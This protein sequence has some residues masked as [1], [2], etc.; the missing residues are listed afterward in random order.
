MRQ[1]HKINKYEAVHI[2]LK[3][4]YGKAS[5]CENEKCLKTST[6]YQWALKNKCRY[7]FNRN[8]FIQLCAKCHSA[9]DHKHKRK[10]KWVD[11]SIRFNSVDIIL[12]RK[13]AQIENRTIKGQFKIIVNSYYKSKYKE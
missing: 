9:Y 12:L 6:L 3:K 11:L 2:W 4:T 10:H 7:S 1:K 8:S 13:L 5:C